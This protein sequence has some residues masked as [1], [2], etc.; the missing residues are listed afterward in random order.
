LARIVHAALLTDI[1]KL[2]NAASLRAAA[3]LNRRGS[4]HRFDY[5][6]GLGLGTRN[7]T[8][9]RSADQI[10]VLKGIAENALKDENLSDAHAFP[11]HFL[12]QVDE[13]TKAFFV[14]VQQLGEAAFADPLRGDQEFWRKCQERWGTGV[15]G[16]KNEIRAWTKEWFD[17]DARKARHEFIEMEIQRRWQ[18]VIDRPGCYR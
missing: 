18:N 12:T 5:W 9:A 1:R 13:T 10:T 15:P 2:R 16:Y 11:R 3:N 7:V 4:W 6:F 8:V 17:N 14:E